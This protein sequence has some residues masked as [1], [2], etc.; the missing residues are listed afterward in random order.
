L[1]SIVSAIP[2]PVLAGIPLK[3]IGEEKDYS[4]DENKFSIVLPKN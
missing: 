3:Y 1:K 4:F 2:L